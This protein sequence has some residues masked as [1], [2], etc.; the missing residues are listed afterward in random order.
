MSIDNSFNHYIVSE[1][2]SEVRTKADLT[3]AKL[4][5]SL[6]ISEQAVKNYEKA[7]S[8]KASSEST[9]RT[10]AIAGMKIETLFNIATKLNVSADYLLGLSGV[11]SINPQLREIVEYTG[12][13]EYAVDCIRSL[14]ESE[15]T[16]FRMQLLNLIL[17][18]PA[19]IY[20]FTDLFYHYA[21][22]NREYLLARNIRQEETRN[23]RKPW[24]E[25]HTVSIGL[26]NKNFEYSVTVKQI[27]NLEDR[28][29]INY[30]RMQ[31][32]LESFLNQIEK[33]F[34]E[35]YLK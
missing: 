24:E 4:A 2:L 11:H 8:Q 17:S 10:K 6:G 32:F 14:N 23:M 9:D 16:W 12:L 7:A 5:E 27:N 19:F 25:D 33:L 26:L 13:D 21:V 30:L 20:G 35:T 18:E 31:R 3:Q 29:D 28:K 22:S 34:R 15:D 1:R